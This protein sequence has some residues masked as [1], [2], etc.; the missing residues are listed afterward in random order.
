MRFLFVNGEFRV[1]YNDDAKAAW[2]LRF[3][4]EEFPGAEY[5]LKDTHRS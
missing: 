5:E 2:A 1:E 3:Y 4:R